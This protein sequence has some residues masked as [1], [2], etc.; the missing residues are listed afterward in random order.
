MRGEVGMVWKGAGARQSKNA[1][2]V[3]REQRWE[4]GQGEGLSSLHRCTSLHALQYN[5]APLGWVQRCND[6]ERLP[7]PCLPL[8]H[9]PPRILSP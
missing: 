5:A 2:A 3:S 6:D 1:E 8:V 4:L 9:L 7:P